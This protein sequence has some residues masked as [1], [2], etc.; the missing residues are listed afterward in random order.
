MAFLSDARRVGYII[1][2]ILC[3]PVL[4]FVKLLPAKSTQRAQ[5][6]EP[7]QEPQ[8]LPGERTDI[9][10][11]PQA[12][13]PESC[14]F[15]RALPLELRRFIYEETL[16]SRQVR[17][18]VS[19]DYE[20]ARN[21]R[22]RF[23]YSQSFDL[24]TPRQ[25]YHRAHPHIDVERSPSS[26]PISIAL[27]RVCRQ[28][29]VE[30]HKV[31]FEDNVFHVV[32]NELDTVMLCG[33]GESIGRPYIRRLHVHYWFRAYHPGTP[34][35]S[36]PATMMF[37]QLAAMPAL[38]D[39]TFHFVDPRT[40]AHLSY[41]Y[42][43]DK[44][45][46]SVWVRR[47]LGTRIPSLHKLEIKFVNPSLPEDL[48]FLGPLAENPKWK[49]VEQKI[50]ELMVG[51]GAEER[52][53]QFLKERAEQRN[54]NLVD[55]LRR[56]SELF[57]WTVEFK[58]AAATTPSEPLRICFPT[59]HWQVMDNVRDR[60]KWTLMNKVWTVESGLDLCPPLQPS[61]RCGS[62][63]SPP[64]LPA[65]FDRWMRWSPRILDGKS[66]DGFCWGSAT[67]ASMKRC[68]RGLG[69]R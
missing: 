57:N 66:V 8:P 44:V 52:Y 58:L 5:P 21:R 29:Y 3:F 37:K 18:F 32:S 55:W 16:G 30:A 11:R 40:P 14:L 13:Q 63:L 19:D 6:A 15:I 50:N 41:G 25:Y 61:Q 17:L 2:V 34:F 27:L 59:S 60:D 26:N 42:D 46:D 20:S 23:V 69:L 51:E 49:V 1:A 28:I 62:C 54:L 33:L 9:H 38:S 43:S 47:L 45:L 64:I 12:T 67:G 10:S 36:D 4:C 35:G 31:L 68:K 65:F 48:S 39:L 7:L 22:R 56:S 24:D 53:R